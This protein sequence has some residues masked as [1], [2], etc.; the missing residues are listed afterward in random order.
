MTSLRDIDEAARFVLS[1]EHG[2]GSN[3]GDDE[4][5][6]LRSALRIVRNQTGRVAELDDDEE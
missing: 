1:R 2:R 4:K 5:R 6:M 3:R